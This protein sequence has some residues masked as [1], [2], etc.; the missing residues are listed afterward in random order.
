MVKKALTPQRDFAAAAHAWKELTAVLGSI[1]MEFTKANAASMT[2]LI[3]EILASGQLCMSD[4]L[5]VFLM[6]WVSEY[7]RQFVQL[8]EAPPAEVL[9]HLIEANGLRQSDLAEEVGGQSVVSAILR[10]KRD[11]N[12]GQAARLAKRFGVSAAVFIGKIRESVASEIGFTDT[13]FK[14]A[15]SNLV[16]PQFTYSSIVAS[17]SHVH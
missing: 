2:L 8:D 16:P 3:N 7:E 6:D 11:I 5:V 4:P 12:A 10:G 17:V 15:G 13:S 14:I 9:R 1:S